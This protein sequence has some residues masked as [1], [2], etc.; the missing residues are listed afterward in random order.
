MLARRL[1]LLF[2]FAVMIPSSAQA[3]FLWIVSRHG[4][5][6]PAA[7]VYFSESAVPDDPELLDRVLKARAWSVGEFGSEPKPLKLAKKD[8]ALV[9][10]LDRERLRMPLVLR[11]TYGVVTRGG[12]TFLIN[13]YAKGYPFPLAGSWR[14]AG[15]DLLPYEIVPQLDDSGVAFKVL[16]QGKPQ[17][18][19]TVTIEGPGLREKVEGTTD[20]K[21]LFHSRLP[22]AGLYSIRARHV[23]TAAGEHDG[24]AYASVR[25][26]TTLALPYSPARLHPTA[27]SFP[28]LA[29]GITS[30]GA[31]VSDDW[32]YVYGGHF[33]GAH[34]YSLEGQSGEFLRLNLRE[35]KAWETLKGGPKLTGV[36]LVSHAGKLYRIGGFTAKNKGS[37]AES[38]WSQTDFSRFDPATKQ[39][40]SLTPLPDGRSSHDAAVLGNTLYVVGGWNMS[41][42]TK[43]WHDTMLSLDLSAADAAWK[44][45]PQPFQRRALSAAVWQD[46]LYAIGGMQ[47]EGESTT[48]VAVYDPA[49]KSWSEGP[50]LVG[51]GLEGFGSSAFASA[52]KLVVTTISGAVQQLSSA[53]KSADAQWEVVGQLQ[54]PRFF[55]RVLARHD[56]QLVI[57]GGASMETGKTLQLEL[58]PVAASQPTAAK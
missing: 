27:H 14:A 47:T 58:L 18:G 4:D 7:N 24:K 43:N 17:T 46:R 26:F 32:L 56:D 3:H 21:G 52:G 25:N 35:P 42:G 40:Q 39:W 54:H 19:D 16:W 11:H 1:P 51:A 30:F 28:P 48:A 33:G 23:E 13:Y 45:I 20:E 22:E 36:A 37:E 50:P 10:E 55:H 53:A 49:T 5:K 15:T 41:D 31:A 29:K 12:E 6:T 34:Q 44:S 8:A 57:V 38:L 2:A 9:A